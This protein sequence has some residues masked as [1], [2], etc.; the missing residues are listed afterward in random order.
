MSVIPFELRVRILAPV[1]L[2]MHRG[3]H[4]VCS[5]R[6]KFMISTPTHCTCSI[7]WSPALGPSQS[8]IRLYCLQPKLLSLLIHNPKLIT[9][10]FYFKMH[11]KYNSLRRIPKYPFLF[12]Y[13]KINLSYEILLGRQ[14][15]C[16]E[17]LFNF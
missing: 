4:L 1:W 14:F 11:S 15:F 7:N 9:L 16:R 8:L 10:H 17:K 13:K 12:Q 6:N 2:C 5:S 3:C